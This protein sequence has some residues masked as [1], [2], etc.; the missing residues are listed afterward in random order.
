AQKRNDEVFVEALAPR[1]GRFH[2]ALAGE[3]VLLLAADVPAL[4]HELGALAHRKTRTRLHDGR[5]D[6]LEVAR[7]QARPWR[8]T[9]A[10]TLAARARQQQLL[11]GTRVHHRRVADGVDAAGE[12]AIDL[13]ER[14]LVGRHDRGFET[15]A[16]GALQIEPGRLR[17]EP[18]RQDTLAC[19]IV[20]A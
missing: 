7:P 13:T 14:D 3:P 16:A 8:Q 11:V 2:V 6:R 17:I 10:E 4:H 18:A 1:G 12:A 20:V 5:Q 19:E 9:L 15:G